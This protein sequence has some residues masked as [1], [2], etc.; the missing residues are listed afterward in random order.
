MGVLLGPWRLP[1]AALERAA[2][3]GHCG[4]SNPAARGQGTGLSEA[5][6]VLQ[7]LSTPH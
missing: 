2:G 4:P 7:G 3:M 1:V 5:L 6:V